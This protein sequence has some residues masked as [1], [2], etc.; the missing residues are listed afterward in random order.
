MSRARWIGA[1]SL[2]WALLVL[3]AFVHLEIA[4][5]SGQGWEQLGNALLIFFAWQ[6]AAA[7]VGIVTGGFLMAWWTGLPGWAR[8][9]GLVPMVGA[10]AALIALLWIV[11][12]P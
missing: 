7:V 11:A 3:G 2:A 9:V 1:L 6:S 12:K 5:A 10:I 4:P 8:A